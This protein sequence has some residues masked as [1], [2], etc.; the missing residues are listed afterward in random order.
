M[1]CH[2]PQIRVLHSTKHHFFLPYCLQQPAKNLFQCSSQDLCFEN[3]NLFTA[4][5]F[6]AGDAYMEP[7]NEA[8]RAESKHFL[9]A[10]WHRWKNTGQ[11]LSLHAC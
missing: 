8:D 7:A 1:A 6:L 9:S 11:S 10:G 5:D 3:L 4:F 2:Q